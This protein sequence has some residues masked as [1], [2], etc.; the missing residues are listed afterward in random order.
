MS[1]RRWFEVHPGHLDSLLGVY[2]WSR[3]GD[4]IL[5]CLKIR[6]E[7]GRW[8]LDFGALEVFLGLL[9]A[10]WFSLFG[11]LVRQKHF[12]LDLIAAVVVLSKRLHGYGC[13]VLN[14]FETWNLFTQQVVFTLVRLLRIIVLKTLGPFSYSSR[15]V[16]FGAFFLTLLSILRFLCPCV[17][18][19]VWQRSAAGP[20]IGKF[21]RRSSSFVDKN[22]TTVFTTQDLPSTVNTV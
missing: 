5:T 6:F 3:C 15:V 9:E 14:F 16:L 7:Q 12:S 18:T 21:P 22:F 4:A 20:F 11:E 2:G 1:L 17:Y 8:P 19:R 10:L 13:T